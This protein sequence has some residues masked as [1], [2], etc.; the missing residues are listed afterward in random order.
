MKKL[1]KGWLAAL[2]AG[3][4]LFTASC[5][6][7]IAG[8]TFTGSKDVKKV[9]NINIDNYGDY[10]T[11]S[12]TSRTIVSD[13]I[14]ADS[15]SFYLWGTA[16]TGAVYGPQEITG[17]TGSSGSVALALSPDCWDLTLAV[18]STSGL[19]TSTDIL[20]DAELIGYATI[21]MTQSSAVTFTLT[22]KDLV[23]KGTVNL[24]LKPTGDDWPVMTNYTIT[25]N[26]V[27]L[28]TGA[29]VAAGLSQTIE[30]TAWKPAGASYT[31]NEV[32]ITPGTYEFDIT[33]EHTENHKKYIWSDVIIILPGRENTAEVEV[34]NI[35]G[36][37]PAA[38]A[39]FKAGYIAGAEEKVHQNLYPVEFV[40]TDNS[41]NETNFVLQFADITDGDV[42]WGNEDT[43]SEYKLN[44][45]GAS[46]MYKSGSLRRNSTTFQLYLELGRKYT[47]RIAAENE[48]GISDY[49]EVTVTDAITAVSD[50]GI[51]AAAAFSPSTVINR[52]R[53][54]YNLEGGVYSEDGS[55]A[56]RNTTNQIVE[57][58]CMDTTDGV[59][60]KN[61]QGTKPDQVTGEGN[62]EYLFNGSLKFAKWVKYDTTAGTETE[63]PTYTPAS[64]ADAASY[65]PDK[66]KEFANLD[67]YARYGGSANWVIYDDSAYNIDVSWLKLNEGAITAVTTAS[68]A[69]TKESGLTFKFVPTA[70]SEVGSPLVADFAYDVVTFTLT[71]GTSTYLA[72]QAEDVAIGGAGASF[73]I[74][75][76]NLPTGRYV[77]KF[78][79]ITGK[80]TVNYTAVIV[81]ND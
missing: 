69:D 34:Q 61:P 50:K 30:D 41:T 2:V 79:A 65:A 67:L 27:D 7:D 32:E 57:Y 46:D 70:S 5:S 73:K 22:A 15:N 60:I 33:F 12:N 66:Y 77:A 72:G 3:L 20:N 16:V 78:T 37:L 71:K 18:C 63:Y 6:H 17:L 1:Y 11:D 51:V 23:K 49:V 9:I 39:A 36:S 80:T 64:G 10:F 68:K 13:A 56:K 4:A 62:A 24:T 81:L 55:A 45:S 74:M 48:V 43:Y 44:L 42:D 25:A 19:T 75:S 53:I 29:P 35:I 54:T 76:T 21:D 59:A 14:T 52:Y 28:Q 38:P 26:I 31:A 47:A 8:G 58:H 40:W